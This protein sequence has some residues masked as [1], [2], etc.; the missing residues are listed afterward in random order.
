MIELWI[1]TQAKYQCA[2]FIGLTM[3]ANKAAV[4]NRVSNASISSYHPFFDETW[5]ICNAYAQNNTSQ[6]VLTSK[7]TAPD[8][9]FAVQ[10]FHTM[11]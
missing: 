8:L 1:A 7:C 2:I 4:M 10:D 5:M 6:F 3:V 9:K 11:K